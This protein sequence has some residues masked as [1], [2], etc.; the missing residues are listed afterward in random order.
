MNRFRRKKKDEPTMPNVVEEETTQ[1]IEKHPS[2]ISLTAEDYR[3]C[4]SEIWNARTIMREYPHYLF[5]HLAIAITAI[6]P[7]NQQYDKYSVGQLKTLKELLSDEGT[8][9]D[10]ALLRKIED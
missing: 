9:I 4:G 1:D 5:V 3:K 7:F 2:E 6:R 10:D 8:A